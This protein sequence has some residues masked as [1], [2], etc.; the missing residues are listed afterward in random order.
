LQELLITATN[1]DD[2]A[3]PTLSKAVVEEPDPNAEYTFEVAS[4]IVTSDG[5]VIDS[6]CCQGPDSGA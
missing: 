3:Q 2:L 1:V 5:T 4:T 6:R